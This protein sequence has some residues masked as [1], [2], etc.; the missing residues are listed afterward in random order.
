[1]HPLRAGCGRWCERTAT[2]S[3]AHAVASNAAWTSIRGATVNRSDARHGHRPLR[4]A[5]AKHSATISSAVPAPILAHG[6]SGQQDRATDTQTPS[7]ACCC[8]AGS[9]T[10]TST[11][12]SSTSHTGSS[13]DDAERR[14]G[15]CCVAGS[16][17]RRTAIW[18]TSSSA[19][20]SASL[21]IVSRLALSRGAPRRAPGA[22]KLPTQ[23]DSRDAS[24]G[25]MATGSGL[26]M[27]RCH[28]AGAGFAIAD[29]V[30]AG[31]ARRRQSNADGRRLAEHYLVVVAASMRRQAAPMRSARACARA[32]ELVVDLGAGFG[33]AVRLHGGSAGAARS[34]RAAELSASLRSLAEGLPVHVV[35]DDLLSFPRYLDEPVEHAAVHR[36]Q[37]PPSCDDRCRRCSVERLVGASHRRHACDLRLPT[38]YSVPRPEGRALRPVRSDSDRRPDL[39]SRFD[40]RGRARPRHRVNARAAGWTIRSR[41]IPSCASAPRRWSASMERNGSPFAPT[42][43]RTEWCSCRAGKAP[44]TAETVRPGSAAPSGLLALRPSPARAKALRPELVRSSWRAMLPHTRSQRA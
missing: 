13:L 15:R 12:A 2:A 44:S 27:E 38:S 24:H 41:T 21:S 11:T 36:R 30:E 39:L 16:G 19:P 4:A 18:T 31:R 33:G 23:L 43:A 35:A 40:C 5:R 26:R 10:S 28:P 22:W 6:I 8:N 3:A 1:M 9:W 20:A 32:R 34:M 42:P 17:S 7:S 25:H 29:A 14:R 37:A